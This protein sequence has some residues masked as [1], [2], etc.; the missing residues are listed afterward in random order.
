M[1][2][3]SFGFSSSWPS[4][5]W[6]LEGYATLISKVLSAGNYDVLLLGVEER[7]TQRFFPDWSMQRVDPLSPASAA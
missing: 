4:K 5:N 7:I 3:F 6:H 1:G 2:L